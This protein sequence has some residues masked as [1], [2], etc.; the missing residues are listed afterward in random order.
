MTGALTTNVVSDSDLPGLLG[1]ASLESRKAII[2]I[3]NRRLVFPGAGGYELKLSP[4]STVMALEKAE[5]GHLLLPCTEW[6]KAKAVTAKHVAFN[7]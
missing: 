5:S 4:G 2:D 7:V 6:K 3:G 1:L